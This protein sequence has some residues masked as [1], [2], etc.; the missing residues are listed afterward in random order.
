MRRFAT[1][2]LSLLLAVMLI[3]AIGSNLMIF[4]I[5]NK[6]LAA[7]NF[8]AIGQN[9]ETDFNKEHSF[10]LQA[11]GATGI[12]TFTIKDAPTRGKVT[13][14]DVNTG[15]FTYEPFEDEVGDDFFVFTATTML[16][17]VT[18]S[19]D[20]VVNVTIIDTRFHAV[21][22]TIYVQKNVQYS[23]T[24]QSRNAFESTSYNI[25]TQPSI[26]GVTLHNTSTGDFTYT[27]DT[28]ELGSDTFTFSVTDSN[29]D[30]KTGT[31]NIV[32]METV[33]TANNA[34]YTINKNNVLTKPLTASSVVGAVTF[35]IANGPSHGTVT[36]SGTEFTYTPDNSFVGT[37]SFVFNAT[38]VSAVESLPVVSISNATIT[39]N[40]LEPAPS[41][42]YAD[43]VGHWGETA[44]LNL[45]SD[46]VI[47]GDQVFLEN[48]F[49]PDQPM[50]RIDFILWVLASVDIDSNE[51]ATTTSPFADSHQ[52]PSW[53]NKAAI[54]AYSNGIISGVRDG[55][56]LIIEPYTVLTRAE[57]LTIFYNVVK[58]QLTTGGDNQLDNFGDAKSVP[59][60]ARP[61]IIDLLAN[62]L[63]YGD[64]KNIMPE[65]SITRAMASQLIYNM[66]NYLEQTPVEE[67]N[68]P[69]AEGYSAKENMLRFLS[70]AQLQENLNRLDNTQGGMI[71]IDN[72][73]SIKK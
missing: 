22:Q 62:N 8:T 15:E 34:T 44:A 45:A 32:I 63:M 7:D 43:M 37:D 19:S 28:D 50:R 25:T 57:A 24:L 70:K 49:Y 5:E 14:D 40:I 9:I 6:V 67:N 61:A 33:L 21:N 26:G 55:E 54:A 42:Q 47:R 17:G 48:Y 69:L 35:G 60:W 39:I 73:Y 29:R 20:A 23:G 18:V 13:A 66:Y 12:I 72:N 65:V 16:G 71:T 38:D 36:I 31:V 1:K 4:G 58:D 56:R 41:F 52:Y 46:A 53:I 51:Y 30:V 11:M 3:T 64:G 2:T 68:V 59:D 27:P 10:T